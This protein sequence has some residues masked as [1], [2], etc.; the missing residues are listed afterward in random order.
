VQTLP[1]VRPG[2]E[3]PGQN[4]L[5]GWVIAA[6]TADD[7]P[8]VLALSPRLLRSPPDSAAPTGWVARDRTGSLVGAVVDLPGRA[9]NAAAGAWW[10]SSP[11]TLEGLYAVAAQAWVRAGIMTHRVVLPSGDPLERAV[12]DLGFGHQQAFASAPLTELVL[13]PDRVDGVEVRAATRGDLGVLA[14]LVPLVARGQ[15]EAPVFAPRTPEFFAQL[16]GSL[17]GFVNHPALQALV[18]TEDA[19]A[20]G[21]TLLAQDGPAVEVVL[22]GTVPEHRG[23]GVGRALLAAARAWAVHRGATRVRADWRTTNPTAAR[24]WLSV[25]LVPN[26][27]RWA[28]TIDPTPS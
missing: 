8:E 3:V 25:G 2:S 6:M 28:R 18:A 1:G 21:F 26:A 7:F 16:P 14:D 17:G 10:A 15:G 11:Q 19:T 5:D 23:R 27:Y 24:F 4:V 20:I 13:L 9:G 12:L 22:T